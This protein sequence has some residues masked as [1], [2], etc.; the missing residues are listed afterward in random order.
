MIMIGMIGMI[1]V[2]LK[3]YVYVCILGMT[4]IDKCYTG[5]DM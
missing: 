1:V 5:I 3:V 2:K 4:H